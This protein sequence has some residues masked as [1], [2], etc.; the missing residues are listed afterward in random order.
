[1]FGL[2]RRIITLILI[3][4]ILIFI[5][6]LPILV[7]INQNYSEDTNIHYP[8]PIKNNLIKNEIRDDNLNQ[9]KT[10]AP[11]IN[12]IIYRNHSREFNNDRSVNNVTIRDDA[13]LIIKDCEFWIKGTLQVMDNGRLFVLNSTLHIAPGPVDMHQIVVNFSDNAHI[14]ISDSQLFT[15]PQSNSTPTN[16]SYLLS[17]ANSEVTIIN[18]YLNIKLPKIVDLDIDLTPPTAGTFILAGETIWNIQNCTI[19][20]YLYYENG[21]LIGR[22]FVFTLQ[23]R[24]KLYIKDT[25]GSLEN[26]ETNPFI[27]PVAGY[28]RLENTKIRMGVIDNEVIGEIE[29]INLT[30]SYLNLRDQ[31]KT[32]VLR[33]EIVYNVDLGGVAIYSPTAVEG[34]EKPKATL[35]MEDSVIGTVKDPN[36]SDGIFFAMGNS[37]STIKRCTFNQGVFQAEAKINIIN[38]SINQFIEGSDNGQIIVENSSVE[39]VF[40]GENC[41]LMIH[42]NLE[43]PPIST[44]ST[45]FNSKSEIIANSVKIKTLEVW[46]GDNIPPKLLWGEV[47]CGKCKTL[48]QRIDKTI[49]CYRQTHILGEFSNN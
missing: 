39:K 7:S 10:R 5:P 9:L 42:S 48:L 30:I 23:G 11:A 16:I 2:N 18:S 32:K 4:I 38:C 19:E 21:Q 14:K 20:S 37:T 17:D 36:E 46:P 44:L 29:A 26:S 27:K 43:N 47:G 1:M 45:K 3:F 8:E 35:L 25:V 6:I 49:C 40:L 12:L 13:T 31:T 41:K 22:W 28:V 34:S 24:A 15:H 33:S